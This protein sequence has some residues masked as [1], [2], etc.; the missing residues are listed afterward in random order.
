MCCGWTAAHLAAIGE[1][2]GTYSLAAGL[3]QIC[4]FRQAVG[5]HLEFRLDDSA[6][7]HVGRGISNEA[8]T[9]DPS[10]LK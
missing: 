10:S 3:N 9:L 4:R 2:R 6:A 1:C 5:R 8:R 7:P